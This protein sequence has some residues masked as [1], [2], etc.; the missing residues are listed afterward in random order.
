MTGTQMDYAIFKWINDLAGSTPWLDGIMGFLSQDAE[1][2]FY[3]GI[4]VYW[5]T[6][7]R[8]N[9]KMVGE[10]L[11]SACLAFGIGNILSHW[12]YRNRPFVT[13]HVHLLIDH[14]AN[15][16]FPSDHSI[17]A[18]VI[19][20]SIW[21]FRRKAGSL[22]LLLA[23]FISFSR[24][25]NGVHYPAD[26]IAGAILGILSAAA[27]HRLFI[28]HPIASRAMS[29]GLLVYESIE[30]RIYPKRNKEAA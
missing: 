26:V 22:W 25:W 24:I 7:K 12:F 2:L 30:Q 1:Y 27:V 20:T 28:R 11:L 3:L 14:A 23:A 9:R 17:G 10:S 29:A 5:F 13:H 18:F 16:S 8:E 19:A 6:R 15:A 4:I 21:L